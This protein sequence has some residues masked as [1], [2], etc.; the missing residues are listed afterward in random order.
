MDL[1]V[2][3]KYEI[4]NESVQRLLTED[5]SASGNKAFAGLSRR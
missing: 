3:N 1:F 4:L 2:S 5:E